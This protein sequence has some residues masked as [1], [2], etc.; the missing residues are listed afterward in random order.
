MTRA[1]HCAMNESHQIVCV[2]DPQCPVFLVLMYNLPRSFV[3]L[4][5]INMFIVG[6]L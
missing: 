3:F 5:V 2:R 4:S 6:K 1:F